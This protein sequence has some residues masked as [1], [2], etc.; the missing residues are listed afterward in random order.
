LDGLVKVGVVQYAAGL[1]K[2]ANLAELGRLTRSAAAA[3]ADLV[4][5]PEAAMHDFGLPDFALAAVAETL[6]GP[7]VTALADLARELRATI[8]A[9]MFEAVPGDANRIYNTVVALGP[10]G[11]LI[12]SY[13]K[14]H[15]FDALGWVESDRIAP[16][17]TKHRL[18]FNC[19]DLRVGVM[20]CYDIRFPELGR[21]LADDGAT[22]IAVPSAWVAGP[23]KAAQFRVLAAARAI[24]N[25]AYVAGAVQCPPQYTAESCVIDPFG[26]VVAELGEDPGYAVA[27]ITAKQV[28]DCR[29]RMPSLQNRRWK[30]MPR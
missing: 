21:A 25:V 4:V 30:V 1:D 14:Q 28:A 20:T 26:V 27:E 24:E 5:A 8:V 16:G 29:E 23:H 12:G 7:F 10:A 2:L 9:G 22:L 3:G 15:L 17:D 13:R 19:G 18:V 11:D 6:D